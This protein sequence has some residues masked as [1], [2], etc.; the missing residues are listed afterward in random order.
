VSR[1]YT[2]FPLKPG[3]TV[4]A[5]TLGAVARGIEQA[6]GRI[7]GDQVPPG[8]VNMTGLQALS[9]TRGVNAVEL[10]SALNEY[11][12]WANF[13]DEQFSVY[14]PDAS[15]KGGG[16]NWSSIG[17]GSLGLNRPRLGFDSGPS[18]GITGELIIDSELRPTTIPG[19]ASGP[20]LTHTEFPNGSTPWREF[21]VFVQG[22]LVATTHRLYHGRETVTVPWFAPSAG[23]AASIEV[24]VRSN[25][26]F[27]E[28]ATGLNIRPL[29]INGIQ[30]WAVRPLA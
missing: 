25:I 9:G 1:H 11:R 8:S 12:S 27:L 23:G 18:G 22:R 15:G 4:R 3:Q 26:G 7:E 10:R 5:K 16:S 19:S 30:L 14:P 2:P 28:D 24:R 13:D 17:L 20:R 21:G 29:V 6:S